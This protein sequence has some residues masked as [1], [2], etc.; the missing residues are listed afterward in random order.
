MKRLA[1]IVALLAFCMG[2]HAQEKIYEVKSG[3]ITMEMD[4]M[5]RPTVQEIYFDDYG[6][7]KATISN[8]GDRK[9][10][11][12][13][14]DG[15]NLMV[16][17]AEKSATRMPMG[18]PMMGGPGGGQGRGETINFTN[19]DEKTI[20]K[21]KIKE[22]GKETV[23]GKECTKYQVTVFMMGQPQKQTVWVYKGVTLKTES[24]TGFGEMV[25][26]ATKF[27]EDVEIPASTFALPEGYQ[28]KEMEM[29]RMGGE[30]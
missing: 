16:N 23:A 2:A 22:L 15:A 13:T 30:W 11:M 9:M 24:K 19:L 3:I 27:E 20:K 28:I 25:Q 6:A 8:F 4:M 10:R 12:I 26:A 14:V 29:R 7:K 17:D 1:M 18:G 5:G 21:F